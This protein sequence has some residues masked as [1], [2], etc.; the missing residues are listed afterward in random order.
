MPSGS[1]VA[2][3]SVQPLERTETDE[4]DRVSHSSSPAQPPP[5]AS[6]QMKR[7]SIVGYQKKH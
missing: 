2:R 5:V 7:H 3:G 6:Q 1:G 4:Q